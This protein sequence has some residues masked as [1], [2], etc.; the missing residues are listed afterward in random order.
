[1]NKINKLTHYYYSSNISFFFKPWVK[2]TV[3]AIIFMF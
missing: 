3:V 1:M 2:Q